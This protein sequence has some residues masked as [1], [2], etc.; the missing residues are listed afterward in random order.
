MVLAD[1]DLFFENLDLG[2]GSLICKD[3]IK[4]PGKTVEFENSD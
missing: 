3:G 4:V 2:N 1:S